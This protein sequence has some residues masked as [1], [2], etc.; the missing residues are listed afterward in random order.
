[1]AEHIGESDMLMASPIKVPQLNQVERNLCN[2]QAVSSI[3]TG[4]SFYAS[5]AQWS[6]QETLNFLVAGSNPVGGTVFIF[7]KTI[8]KGEK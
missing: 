2:V 5:V 8:F 1:M 7:N 4:T 6:E 3:L